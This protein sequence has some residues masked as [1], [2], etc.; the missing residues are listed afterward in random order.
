MVHI[1]STNLALS[2]VSEKLEEMLINCALPVEFFYIFLFVLE[3]FYNLY[4]K[5]VEIY[6]L[7]KI[8]YMV[9]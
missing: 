1:H 5:M 3:V 9:S 7:H 6:S 4:Y 2:V 8:F